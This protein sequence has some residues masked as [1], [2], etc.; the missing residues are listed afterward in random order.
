MIHFCRLLL[1]RASILCERTLARQKYPRKGLRVGL[2][3]P[4]HSNPKTSESYEKARHRSSSK[5]ISYVVFKFPFQVVIMEPSQREAARHPSL[6]LASK[7]RAAAELGWIHLAAR[8][9][10]HGQHATARQHQPKPRFTARERLCS[11]GLHA[12][13]LQP[14][15]SPQPPSTST[16]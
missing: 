1:R 6:S 13:P 3:A 7:P 15:A 2:C 14:A 11:A 10:P 12:L 8:R 9:Q 4:A 5:S 16:V